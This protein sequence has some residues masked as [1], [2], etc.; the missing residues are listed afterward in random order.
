MQAMWVAKN[1]ERIEEDI[2]D[3]NLKPAIATKAWSK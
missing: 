1:L 2:P 3:F